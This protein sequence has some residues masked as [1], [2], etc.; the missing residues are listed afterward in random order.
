MI[1]AEAGEGNTAQAVRVKVS[2][3]LHAQVFGVTTMLLEDG[4]I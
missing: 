2:T 4:R 3:A 1:D